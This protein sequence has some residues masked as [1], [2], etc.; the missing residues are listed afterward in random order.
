MGD[1]QRLPLI[2]GSFTAKH[3]HKRGPLQL[4]PALQ[5][6]FLPPQVVH[7]PLQEGLGLGI[8]VNL[9]LVIPQAVQESLQESPAQTKAVYPGHFSL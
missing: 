4:S 6:H 3:L 8:S 1:L 7:V 5:Q 9:Y 2:S